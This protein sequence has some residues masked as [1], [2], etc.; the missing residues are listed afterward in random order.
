MVLLFLLETASTNL[1]ALSLV[2]VRT[3]QRFFPS[4]TPLLYKSF[5]PCIPSA[6]D[7]PYTASTADS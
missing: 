5:T 2:L 7:K 3:R 1:I 4:N 6:I